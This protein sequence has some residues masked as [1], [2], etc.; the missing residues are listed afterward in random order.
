MYGQAQIRVYS[1]HM[2]TAVFGTPSC[3]QSKASFGSGL[4]P[5]PLTMAG[6]S[7]RCGAPSAQLLSLSAFQT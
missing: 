7:P 6:A 1:A 4:G 2:S 3:L 5:M